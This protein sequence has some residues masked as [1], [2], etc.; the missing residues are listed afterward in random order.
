MI[1]VG[2]FLIIFKMHSL[3]RQVQGEYGRSEWVSFLCRWA[4]VINSAWCTH[5]EPSGR[6]AHRMSP[7][8][9]PSAPWSLTWNKHTHQDHI[10]HTHKLQWHKY[11]TQVFFFPLI[12]SNIQVANELN[13]NRCKRHCEPL[14]LTEWDHR[15]TLWSETCTSPCSLL[16]GSQEDFH[17][18]VD[19]LH[20]AEGFEELLGN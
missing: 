12:C 20:S 15:A 6:A 8:T 5:S 11:P 1:P 19:V 17:V 16:V 9:R 4:G 10:L 14:P 13:K 2:N 18:L 3:I 7:V